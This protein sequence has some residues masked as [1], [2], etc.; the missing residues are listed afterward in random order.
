MRLRTSELNVAS[1]ISLDFADERV[2]N[3]EVADAPKV[4]VLLLNLGG[5]ETGDDVEGKLTLEEREIYI[6]KVGHPSIASLAH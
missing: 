2:N 4:G 1:A 6:P 5:P 3:A